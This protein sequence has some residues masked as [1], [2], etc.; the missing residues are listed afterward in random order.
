MRIA[1]TRGVSPNINQCELSHLPRQQIDVALAAAQ[2]QQYESALREAGATVISLPS[3]PDLPD[4][5]FVEDPAVVVDEVAVLTH[6]GAGSRRR[7][8]ECLAATL[9]RYRP[10]VWMRA[11]A[12]L[13][14]GDVQRVGSTLFVGASQRTNEAGMHQLAEELRPF[15]YTVKPVD[16]FGCLHLKS[17]ACAVGPKTILANRDWVDTAAFEGFEI[18]DVPPE[19]PRAANVLIIGETALLPACFPATARLLESRGL[20]VKPLD[21]SELMKAEAG[22]TCSTIL[23]ETDE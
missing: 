18:L 8:S 2:H 17:G 11:P 5:M 3:E 20:K 9:A 12:T 14:G 7:E 10:L 4:S 23:L 21:I 16:V 15:G 6:M 1:I 19:E 13:E 22:V